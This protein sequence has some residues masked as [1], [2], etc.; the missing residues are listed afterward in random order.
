MGRIK[1]SIKD[2]I[3]ELYYVKRY[4]YSGIMSYYNN[5]YT[6]AEIRKIILENEKNMA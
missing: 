5:K 3:A 6:Y 2:E 1:K 4:T